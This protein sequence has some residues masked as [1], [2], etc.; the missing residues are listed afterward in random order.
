MSAL[1]AGFFLLG[2]EATSLDAFDA[3]LTQVALAYD[4]QGALR[5]ADDVHE[6]YAVVHERDVAFLLAR[7]LLL[8]ADLHRMEYEFLPE[9]DG[10]GRRAYGTIIDDAATEGLDLLEVADNT[11]EVWRMRA[12]L[13]GVMIRSDYR[14]TRF[15]K[16]MDDAIAKALELDPDDPHAHVS[17]ARPLVFAD[18]AHGQDFEAALEHLEEALAVNPTL[19]SARVLKAVTL[20]RM[21]RAEEAISQWKALLEDNPDCIPAQRRLEASK[22]KNLTTNEHK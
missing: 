17:A 16:R 19:E 1:L 13:Y 22:S 2:A 9:S 12:D 10:E 20:E 14:A 21:E 5:L 18:A 8:V 6:H 11:A 3:R 7:A 15:Q 4:A